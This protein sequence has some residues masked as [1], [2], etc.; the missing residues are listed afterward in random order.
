MNPAATCTT[1]QG[2][3]SVTKRVEI[4]KVQK[5]LSRHVKSTSSKSPARQVKTQRFKKSRREVKGSRFKNPRSPP[6]CEKAPGSQSCRHVVV[7]C[8]PNSAFASAVALHE[9]IVMTRSQFATRCFVALGSSC[10]PSPNLFGSS[11]SFSCE[12]L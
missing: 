3:K 11:V 12:S 8:V 6:Q 5:V 1:A 9:I 10:L 4:H 7:A 2:S